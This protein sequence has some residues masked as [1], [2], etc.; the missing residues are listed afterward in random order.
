[1]HISM[2]SDDE[3]WILQRIAQQKK[4]KKAVDLEEENYDSDN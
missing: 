1:M 3:K 4:G 2:K